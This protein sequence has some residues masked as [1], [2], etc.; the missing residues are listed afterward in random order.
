LGLLRPAAAPLRPKRADSRKRC[1]ATAYAGF[2]GAQAQ[3]SYVFAPGNPDLGYLVF[4]KA[5]QEAVSEV[6]G[7]GGAQMVRLWLGEQRGRH[8]EI[9]PYGD[10]VWVSSGTR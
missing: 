6:V 1:T 10:C 5:L 9:P 8:E 3:R 7:A 2:P 4:E